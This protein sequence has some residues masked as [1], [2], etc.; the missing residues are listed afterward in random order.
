MLQFFKQETYELVYMP[1]TN[2]Y[3][4]ALSHII[5]L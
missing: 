4:F 1:E 3:T 5:K 2:L